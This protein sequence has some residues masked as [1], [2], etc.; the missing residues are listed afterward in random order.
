[1]TNERH[2]HDIYQSELDAAKERVQRELDHYKEVNAH[3]Q[4]MQDIKK[5]FGLT[6]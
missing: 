4:K 1:M 5:T 3:L 2:F 6:N